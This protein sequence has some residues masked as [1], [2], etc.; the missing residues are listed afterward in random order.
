MHTQAGGKDEMKRSWVTL[1]CVGP[2]YPRMSFEILEIFLRYD[3]HNL[4]SILL[5]S[6]QKE[7]NIC[8][9]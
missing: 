2:L 1:Q 6:V 3:I 5:T 4:K 9:K 7:V 8:R